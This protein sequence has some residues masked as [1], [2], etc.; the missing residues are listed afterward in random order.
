M[1]IPLM[2]ALAGEKG[3]FLGSTNIILLNILFWTYGIKMLKAG[4][5]LSLKQIL[6]NPGVIAV[7]LGLLLFLS[8]WKLPEPAYIAV[9]SLGDLNTP[10]AMIVLGGFLAQTNFKE[11]FKNLSFY[12]ICLIKLFLVPCILFFIF[13]WIPM[14]HEIKIVAS[15]CAVT[16]SATAVPMFAEICGKD[17]RYASGAVMINSVFAAV[18]IPIMLTVAKM[19]LGF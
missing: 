7:V 16:P 1:A 9:S 8:P 5:P 13:L 19:I 17:A 3:V 15:I 10:L 2:L 18:T 6:L 12:K 14:P 11:I 4:A